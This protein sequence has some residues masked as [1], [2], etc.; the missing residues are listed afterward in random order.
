MPFRD[1]RAFLE[2]LDA[3]GEL[4]RIQ[5]RVA[6]A[7]EL[8]A[9]SYLNAQAGGPALLFERPD[10]RD[11]PVAVDVLGGWKRYALAMETEVAQVHG[12]W[13]RRTATPL[14][15]RRVA[16]GPCKENVLRGDAVD[17]FKFSMPTWNALDG[18]PYITFPV[19]ISQDVE[20]GVR[21]CAIYRMQVHGPDRVGILAESYRH[22]N[23]HRRKYG[24]KEPFPIAIALGTD[25]T[26]PMAA[27]APFPFGTDE[28]AM[29]G[30]IRGEPV[31]VVACETV[32]L[33]VPA[34]AEIVLEGEMLPGEME[35]E[36]PY[37][38]FT[39]YY[40]P[41]GR[42]PV[43]R[44]KAITHRDHPIHVGHY[45]GR[46][47]GEATALSVV[48][49]ECEILRAVPIPGIQRVTITPGGRGLLCIASIKQMF[50]GHGA[51]M[52][53]AILSTWAGRRIK[54]VI[55]VDEDVD[56]TNWFDVEWAISTRVQPHRDV[57]IIP[58]APGVGLDPSL[59]DDER[60]TG[61]TS[62]MI[63][64]ATK[65]NTATFATPCLPN[66]DVLAEVQRNWAS[67]GIPEGSGI[68]AA[69]G[70]PS[71]AVRI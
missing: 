46:V 37:G 11:V 5:R 41:R 30:A 44:I 58:V 57:T 23:L 9:V 20:T 47:A 53:M 3:H 67:Y 65:Y 24:D 69:R 15:T 63:I 16:S 13:T 25:P 61:R 7:Y 42:R 17:L 55:V 68:E 19:I 8:G 64:D 32:P 18:G 62:K 50:A 49:I 27:V 28:L 6:L 48:P 43:V 51:Q 39:G 1:L 31:D 14:P 34:A 40:G 70:I 21:N 71:T 36:G 22:L 10:D 4:A 12:E 35:E 29:A 54:S 33:E 60:S 56:P 59:P 2:C 38:E 26:I 45:T 52:G 66:A